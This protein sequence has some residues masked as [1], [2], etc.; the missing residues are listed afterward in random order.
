MTVDV[1]FV[2]EL[3]Q[4]WM[5]MIDAIS[6]PLVIVDS[7]YNVVRQNHAYVDQAANP[8]DLSIREFQSEKCFEIFAGR[9]SPCSHCKIPQVF[10][11]RQNTTWST[12]QLFEGRQTE[13]RAHLQNSATKDSKL[14]ENLR[15]VVHYRDVT[16]FQNMQESLARSDKLAALGKLAGGVAHEINSPL[17]GVLAFAQ[18]ALKEMQESNPHRSDMV[19]IEDAARKCKVIVEGLLGFAR[20]EKPDEVSQF[21]F[22]DVVRSAL[23]L[24]HPLI[25]TNRIEVFTQWEDRNTPWVTGSSGKLSQVFLNLITNAIYAMKEGGGTLEVVGRI[26]QNRVVVEVRDSGV[27]ID[28]LVLGRIFDPFF[29]TKP[30]GEGTGLGLSIS[31]S[32]VKQ[33]DGDIRVSSTEGIGTTFT[34]VLPLLNTQ[35]QSDFSPE[36]ST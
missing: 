15:V 30:I 23:R 12:G 3:K 32:I 20:Q 14:S 29:T 9:S 21:N 34:V 5:A 11:T 1:E 31:Y 17:A 10:E 6:D 33:H 35:S 2:E 13:I 27:G 16:D 26:D 7:Q 19:E 24:A 25:R 36:A 28:A 22:F 4:Q 18:M 8:A